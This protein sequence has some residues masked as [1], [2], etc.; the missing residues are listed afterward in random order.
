MQQFFPLHE[1][2]RERSHRGRPY[3]EFL[4]VSALSAGIYVLPAGSTDQQQPH[5]EDEIY[6]VVRGRSRMRLRNADGSE[7]DFSVS[8]EQ[9]IFIPARQEHR[10]HTIEEDLTLLVVFAPAETT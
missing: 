4:R 9:T 8:P 2:Q 5:S 7:E 10:F 1:L 6:Y 3:L